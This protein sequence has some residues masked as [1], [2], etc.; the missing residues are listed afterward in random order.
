MDKNKKNF[1]QLK[2]LLVDIDGTLYFKGKVIPGAIETVSKLCEAG[3]RV[4]FLTNTDSKSPKTIL[5]ILKDYGF[6]INE[7]E[8]FTPVIALKKFLSEYLTKKSY[9]VTTVEVEKEFQDFQQVKGSE[10]PDFV[11]IGDFHDNWDVNRLNQ[12][13]K[14]VLKGAKLLGMQ[15]NKYYLDRNGEP[16]IDTGSFVQMIANAANVTPKIF[17]KPSKEYFLQALN[18]I[19]LGIDEVI[20]IGDDIETDIQ[21]AINVGF[22]GILVKTGKGKYFESA[23]SDIKPFLVIESF[24]SLLD[25]LLE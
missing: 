12:A 22:K 17:G 5:K 8:I 6:T 3:L 24:S 7:D 15:G 11:I 4:L 1:S 23:K 20:V 25:L 9:F 18:K 2:G 10:L 19:N 16:V 13:F 21:G 14:F